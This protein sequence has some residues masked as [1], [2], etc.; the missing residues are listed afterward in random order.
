MTAMPAA[1]LVLLP[2]LICDARIFAGQ[3]AAF[4]AAIAMAYDDQATDLAAMAARVLDRAPPRFALLGHSMG[5]RV[6]LEIVRAA[7]HRVE[8]LALVST[9]VHE[10]RPGEAAKRHA[11]RDLGREQGMAALVAAWLPPMIA[12][13]NARNEALVA[14]L[15]QMCIDAGLARYEA[16]VAAL[17]SRPEVESLLPRITCPTLVATGSLDVWSPPAQ[18]QDIAAA[19]PNATLHSIAGAGHM[20]PAENPQAMNDAIRAWLSYPL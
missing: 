18:H 3:L 5:G 1:P 8:R 16:Q 14:S 13:E 17:L 4:P 19:V 2:G 6:A 12:A 9:G 7:P 20:L 10:I 15:S 11:L